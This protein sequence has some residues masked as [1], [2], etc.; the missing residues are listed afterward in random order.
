MHLLAGVT[1]P[2]QIAAHVLTHLLL[3]VEQK[4]YGKV[5]KAVISVRMI[6]A[7][8]L[9]PGFACMNVVICPACLPCGSSR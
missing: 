5:S 3:A 6:F 1:T 4:G 9:V 7:S 2:E 8:F